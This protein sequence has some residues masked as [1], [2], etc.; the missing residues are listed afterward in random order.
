MRV[1]EEFKL[2]QQLVERVLQDNPLASDIIYN[3][4]VNTIVL[5]FKDAKILVMQ[6]AKYSSLASAE[7]QLDEIIKKDPT[8]R[9]PDFIIF[10]EFWIAENGVPDHNHAGNCHKRNFIL[11]YFWIY[12][13]SLTPG[14]VNR[15][16]VVAKKYNCYIVLGTLVEILDNARYITAPIICPQ[17]ELIGA[18][19]K[20]KPTGIEIT[21]GNQIFAMDTKFGRVT[22]MICFDIENA[23]IFDENM[24]QKPF[25]ML[26]PVCIPSPIM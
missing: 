17:G 11:F 16:K 15:F 12:S 18:Y 6:T 4:N 13:I 22:V 7:Q 21:P 9:V 5:P 8:G 10:P 3:A 1:Y 23:D 2:H 26:N 14:S 19:R 25:L 24:A 20:R